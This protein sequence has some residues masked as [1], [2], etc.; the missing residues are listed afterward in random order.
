[1]R[2]GTLGLGSL[3]GKGRD[4]CE[5]LRMR[6]ID[7]CCL[8]EVRWRGQGARM[9]G[10]NGGRYELWWSGKLYVVGGVGVMV[11][12]EMCKK[13]LEVRRACD[14]VMTVV[15]VFEEYVLRLICGCALQ[16]G[17]SFEEKQSF[18]YKLKCEWD[19]HSAGD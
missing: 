16:S 8:Q 1:M 18:Y 2:V 17:G 9:L 4:V 12:E 14:R 11:K 5:E 6:M 13:M 7:V 19:M 15:V 3:S 10:I